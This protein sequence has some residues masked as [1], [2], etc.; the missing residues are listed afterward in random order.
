MNEYPKSHNF[1]GPDFLIYLAF[2][3]M[4]QELIRRLVFPSDV[5]PTRLF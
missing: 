5:T 1:F 4:L 3:T 2:V